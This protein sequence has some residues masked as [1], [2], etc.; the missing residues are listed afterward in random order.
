VFLVIYTIYNIK[1][2]FELFVTFMRLRSK[3]WLS[4]RFDVLFMHYN[5][6]FDAFYFVQSV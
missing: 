4:M 2:I 6:G 5:V 1:L 3:L